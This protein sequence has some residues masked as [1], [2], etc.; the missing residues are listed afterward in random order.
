MARL[1]DD[2][3]GNDKLISWLRMTFPESREESALRPGK[4]DNPITS[5]QGREKKDFEILRLI[6][7]H[8][9]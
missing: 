1:L 2:Q 9:L 5:R 6:N 8:R 7:S 4:P 3:T